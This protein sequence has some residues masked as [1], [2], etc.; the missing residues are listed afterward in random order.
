MNI[1]SVQLAS[2]FKIFFHWSFFV[3]QRLRAGAI[4]EEEKLTRWSGA[5]Q[6]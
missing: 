6:L 2:G 1:R 4:L 5:V 3:G